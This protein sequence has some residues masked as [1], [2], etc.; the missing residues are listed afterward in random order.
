M[1]L[2]FDYIAPL[3][4]LFGCLLSPWVVARHASLIC[5]QFMVR[6][7]ELALAKGQGAL[8]SFVSTNEALASMFIVFLVL[9][10]VRCL[11]RF[12]CCRLF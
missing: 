11:L 3:I 2:I 4:T 8:T 1:P 10:Q 6:A 12:A 7:A 5:L 9:S